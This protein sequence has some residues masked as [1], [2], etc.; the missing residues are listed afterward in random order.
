MLTDGIF[1]SYTIRMRK[2]L[3]TKTVD[4]LVPK[5]PKRLEV[6]DQTLPGFGV[7]VS[8]NGHKSWFCAVRV[9]SRLRRCTLG[10]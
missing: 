1:V 8:V 10:P 3:T 7:R 4:A 6:Y 5:G 9:D 2:K